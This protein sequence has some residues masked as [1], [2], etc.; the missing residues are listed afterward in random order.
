MEHRFHPSDLSGHPLDRSHRHGDRFT[1]L[2]RLSTSDCGETMDPCPL[3]KR[4]YLHRCVVQKSGCVPRPL[5]RK[6]ALE[7]SS[8]CMSIPHQEGLRNSMRIRC[9]VECT[10]KTFWDW[11]GCSVG[12]FKRIPIGSP[13]IPPLQREVTLDV[14][15]FI[16]GRACRSRH[17]P[18]VGRKYFVRSV[19]PPDDRRDAGRQARAPQ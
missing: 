17:Q 5:D 14:P 4:R 16:A 3:D 13:L 11:V 18:A 9:L 7:G 6:F 1:Y 2:P 19:M 12:C 15:S 8:W 10:L